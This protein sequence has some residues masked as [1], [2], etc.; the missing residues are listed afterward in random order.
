MVSRLPPSLNNTSGFPTDGFLGCSRAASSNWFQN[1][2]FHLAQPVVLVHFSG[3]SDVD[4]VCDKSYDLCDLC[5]H[6]T[7]IKGY[8]T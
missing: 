6:M 3:S 4:Q 5:L 7:K 8:V 1:R 2:L